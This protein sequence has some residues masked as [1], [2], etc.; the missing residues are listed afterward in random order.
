MSAAPAS[1]PKAEPHGIHAALSAWLGSFIPG[2][3]AVNARERWRVAAGAALGV[4]FVA[5]LCRWSGGAD[6]ALP[7][8]VAPMGA[9][10]LLVFGVPASPMAQPW[11]VVAGNA[12]SMLVGIG[13][14]HAFGA[15]PWAAA[16]AVGLAIALMF[17]LRCL[18][19]PGGA[20]ALLAVLSGVH[21]PA[22]VLFPVFT[23]AVLLVLGGCIYN[24]LTGRRYPHRQRPAAA[25]VVAGTQEGVDSRFTEADL[26]A[27]LSRYNQV[28]D[29]S[30]DDLRELLQEA[31]V[32]AYRRRMGTER[33]EDVMTRE[34][35]SVQFGTPLQE[36]WV[37]L[38]EHHIKA[39]PV[40][41]R[42]RRLI[43]IVTLA[44]FMRGA[45][46]DMHEGWATRLR[47]LLRPTPHSHSDKPEVVG[48]I[49]NTRVRVASFDRP[50]AEL[51]PIFAAS[52]H[53]HIPIIDA[54]QR[55]VGIVTQTDLVAALCRPA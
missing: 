50:L 7:W 25:P 22:F 38:R 9:S 55:L 53:H 23:N 48:Q 44:D 24:T 36:A 12:L 16:L 46:I 8:L 28:L 33:C 3:M 54:E 17:A 47:A 51:V 40:V 29:V 21:D 1:P 49:M 26:D 41:D 19:P 27:V 31:E 15:S 5:L 10:A 52:G 18:H 43:G 13:C 2:R 14:V 32:Q 35:I 37:L 11:A 30:R 4:L 6:A 42:A 20:S 39:L 34:P 45:D